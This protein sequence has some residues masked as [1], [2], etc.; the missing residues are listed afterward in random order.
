VIFLILSIN[1]FAEEFRL[2]PVQADDFPINVIAKI[3]GDGDCLVATTTRLYHWNRS[4]D[5]VREIGAEGPGFARISAFHYTGTY[6][7]ISGTLSEPRTLG[8][9]LYDGTGKYLSHLV[10]FD[11][12][13]RFFREAGGRLF[14]LQGIDEI[15]TTKQPFFF[16]ANE[17][18]YSVKND[19]LSF[20][21]SAGLCKVSPLVQQLVYNFK[22]VWLVERDGIF[23]AANEVDPVIYSYDKATIEIERKEGPKAP[24]RAK[25][26]E[27]NLSRFVRGQESFT[28]RKPVPSREIPKLQYNWFYSWSRITGFYAYKSGYVV[29]YDIPECDNE[30]NCESLLGV[31]VLDAEFK[32][33]GPALVTSGLL[34]GVY[35]D[36]ICIF[37]PH[38]QNVSAFHASGMAPVMRMLRP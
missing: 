17:I 16:L 21:F 33:R 13:V 8:S 35:Q 9:V 27:L 7:W 34:T 19:K 4:G 1:V 29:S 28:L 14:G 30:G 12:Y 10:G 11:S 3:G 26:H 37:E 5:M 18:V 25:F 15:Y 23:Y 31:Q 32:N 2:A 36:Q 38:F 20:S 22:L 24:G 6:Y